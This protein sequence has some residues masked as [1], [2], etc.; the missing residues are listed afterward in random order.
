MGIA[1]VEVFEMD[2]CMVD[3]CKTDQREASFFAVSKNRSS[4][5]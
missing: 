2:L 1:L 3:P 4:Y 5:S